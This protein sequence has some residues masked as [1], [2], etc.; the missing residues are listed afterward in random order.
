MELLSN[1]LPEF[2]TAFG[3]ALTTWFFT[4]KKNKQ[5]VNSLELENVD[6]ALDIYRKMIEDITSQKESLNNQYQEILDNHKVLL[7]DN[8]KL[9]EDHKKMMVEVKSLKKDI[10][11]LTKENKHLSSLIEAKGTK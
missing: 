11:Y 3:T 1:Y 10:E 7:N 8:K 2:L 6:K 9:L 5:E 4:R